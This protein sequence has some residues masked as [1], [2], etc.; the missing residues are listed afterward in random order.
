VEED[1]ED[2]EEVEEEEEEYD[3]DPF[4]EYYREGGDGGDADEN[5]RGEPGSALNVD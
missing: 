2:E 1:D 4:G 3:Q 5:R